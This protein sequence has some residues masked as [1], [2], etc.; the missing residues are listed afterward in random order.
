[1]LMYT[2]ELKRPL[3]EPLSSKREAVDQLLEKLNLSRCR[4]VKIGNPLNKGI[5]GGQAKRTSE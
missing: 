1:M 5:S 3:S 2:A 4:D